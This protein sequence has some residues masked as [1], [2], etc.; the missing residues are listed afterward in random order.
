M[1]KHGTMNPTKGILLDTALAM[2]KEDG[3]ENFSARKL[4]ERCGLTHQAPYRYFKNKDTLIE[5]MAEEV[6]NRLTV[7]VNRQ[8]KRRSGEEAFLVLIEEM[9]RFLVN[10]PSYGLLFYSEHRTGPAG[11]R[12]GGRDQRFYARF[13]DTAQTHLM[14]C[15]VPEEEWEDTT[16]AIYA[17]LSGL[18][19]R[20]INK[21][22]I[23]DGALAP[24][25][26]IIIEDIL[27]LKPKK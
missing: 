12:A 26:R 8:M 3:I 2:V 9:I 14:K 1:T 13:R 10:D 17:I 11:C 18:I 19:I 4:A 24:V 6:C 22:V 7:Y 21:A 20:I 27:H 25:V 15:C 16:D 5:G 23:I